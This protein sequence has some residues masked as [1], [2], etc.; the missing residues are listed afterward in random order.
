MLNLRDCTSLAA[1]ASSPTF[2]CPRS[3]PTIPLTAFLCPKAL[4]SE[5][6]V[7]YEYGHCPQL[8]LTQMYSTKPCSG[9]CLQPLRTCQGLQS[10]LAVIIL[11]D[12]GHWGTAGGH[13]HWKRPCALLMAGR[14]P[15]AIFTFWT[16]NKCSRSW[17][18]VWRHPDIWGQEK[19]WQAWANN[20]GSYFQEREVIFSS[21]EI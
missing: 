21:F 5:S 12:M 16:M 14:A 9:P 2:S 18:T 10:V 20:T 15:S 7:S 19:P 6:I 3:N 13:R 8:M 17:M 1:A 11:T 4:K